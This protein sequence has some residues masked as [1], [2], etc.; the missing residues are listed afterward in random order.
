MT[1]LAIKKQ[2]TF[3]IL[4]I[5]FFLFKKVGL[6]SQ[7]NHLLRIEEGG[8][9]KSKKWMLSPW[10]INGSRIMGFHFLSF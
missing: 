8:S 9:V 2:M 5:I 4:L 7:L 10:K 6:I 3:Y 1:F